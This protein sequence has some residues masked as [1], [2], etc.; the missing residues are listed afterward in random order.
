MA[1]LRF[2]IRHGVTRRVF[3]MG[4]YA[5][6]VPQT[7]NGFTCFL[8]GL[9]ANMKER[10]LTRLN[11]QRLVPVLWGMRGGLLIVMPRCRPISD[12]EYGQFNLDGFMSIGHPG[13]KYQMADIDAKQIN[14]GWL[15]GKVRLLDYGS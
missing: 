2:A 13:A 7:R 11:D 12:F 3:L 9:L 5:L 6:K 15:W 4:G 14:F 10:E 1:E 8:M